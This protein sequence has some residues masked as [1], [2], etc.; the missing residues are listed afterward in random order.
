MSTI[1]IPSRTAQV[2]GQNAK[3][4]DVYINW[5]IMNPTDVP[6]WVDI[7]LVVEKEDWRVTGRY[8]DEAWVIYDP[9]YGFVFDYSQQIFADELR[10]QK[11]LGNTAWNS[12]KSLLMLPTGSDFQYDVPEKDFQVSPRIQCEMRNTPT[13]IRPRTT[14]TIRPTLRMPGPGASAGMR[15]FWSNYVSPDFHLSFDLIQL[16]HYSEDKP[17]PF[18]RG[19]VTIASNKRIKNAFKLEM[20]KETIVEGGWGGY[21]DDY[22]DIPPSTR[23]WRSSPKGAVHTGEVTGFGGFIRGIL[24]RD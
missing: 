17:R 14:R 24:G 11:S 15:E 22:E 8:Y 5:K 18:S 23:E 4:F 2:N 16:S 1:I 6:M 9:S 3:Y 21:G 7:R 13:L 10:V 19:E 12:M 20:G